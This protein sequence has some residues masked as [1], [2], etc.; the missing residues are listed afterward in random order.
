MSNLHKEYWP[1]SENGKWKCKERELKV[2]VNYDKQLGYRV[3]VVPVKTSDM[4]R[5][6]TMEEYGAYTGFKDTLLEVNRQSS[7]RLQQALKILE[8]N[9]DR[10]I[11]WFIDTTDTL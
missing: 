3:V 2:A 6:I 5:G 8:E 1:L 4:G 7:K 11:R 10:Y 9:K